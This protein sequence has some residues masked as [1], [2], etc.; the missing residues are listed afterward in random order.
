MIPGQFATHQGRT[1]QVL[2]IEGGQTRGFGSLRTPK[3]F[4]LRPYPEGETYTVTDPG[5]D[6]TACETPAGYQPPPAPVVPPQA[7]SYTSGRPW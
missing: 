4:T 5:P 3:V 7:R 2:R 6:L 1:V